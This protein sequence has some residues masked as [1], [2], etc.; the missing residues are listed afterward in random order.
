MRSR[1]SDRIPDCQ[2]GVNVEEKNMNIR[3]PE[4]LT[5]PQGLKNLEITHQ[6][7]I[8]WIFPQI[9][10]WILGRAAIS[11]GDFETKSTELKESVNCADNRIDEGSKEC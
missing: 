11:H 2:F 7:E 5:Q 1:V 8:Q 3:E 6:W 10:A 4:S 9:Q